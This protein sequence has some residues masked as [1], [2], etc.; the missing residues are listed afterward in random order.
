M[1]VLLM[2]QLIEMVMTDG[3]YDGDVDGSDDGDGDD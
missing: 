2:V 1:I 3:D